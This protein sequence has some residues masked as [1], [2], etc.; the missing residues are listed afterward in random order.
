MN[1]LSQVLIVS[2]ACLSVSALDRKARLDMNQKAYI[3]NNPVLGDG[4]GQD[5]L[6]KCVALAAQFVENPMAPTVKVCGTGIRL[7]VYLLGRCGEGSLQNAHL[8]HSWEIG[9]CDTGLDPKTC[10]E[11]GPRQ[12]KRMGV[13]QSYKITTCG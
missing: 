7:T 13:S 12:D 8:G 3:E 10:V 2:A 9:A 5:R 4:A 6:N 1:R 11:K